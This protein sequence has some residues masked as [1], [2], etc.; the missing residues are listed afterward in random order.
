MYASLPLPLR[1]Q[2]IDFECGGDDFGAPC[3]LLAHLLC[4][5]SLPRL[6]SQLIENP[7]PVG[8]ASELMQHRMA[9]INLA[10]NIDTR[11]Q[12]MYEVRTVRT[13]AQLS[14]LCPRAQL[15]KAKDCAHAS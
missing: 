14:Q 1:S 13:H 6:C 9:I 3:S 8:S 4:S 5:H 15:S 7:W 10:A 12:K 11:I 2:L